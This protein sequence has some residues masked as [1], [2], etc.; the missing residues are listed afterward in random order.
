MHNALASLGVLMF[1]LKTSTSFEVLGVNVC[2]FKNI[3]LDLTVANI[4]RIRFKNQIFEVIYLI[5]HRIRGKIVVAQFIGQTLEI[6]HFS[7]SAQ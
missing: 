5:L 1:D 7:R 2:C 6:A 3:A 4:G